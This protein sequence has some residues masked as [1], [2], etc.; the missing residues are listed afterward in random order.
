MGVKKYLTLV[1]YFIVV[2]TISTTMHIST[3]LTYFQFVAPVKSHIIITRKSF[4][5]GALHN[6]TIQG[7][8]DK[9]F[10]SVGG[11]P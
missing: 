4:C 6:T 2:I 8:L 3:S 11:D 9:C 7:N 5:T 10:W 1:F